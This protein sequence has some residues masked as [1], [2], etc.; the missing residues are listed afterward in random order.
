VVQIR[1]CK[2]PHYAV[3]PVTSSLL[4]PNV[5]RAL[6]SNTLNVRTILLMRHITGHKSHHIYIRTIGRSTSEHVTPEV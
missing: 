1:N 5:K 2:A 6:F 3:S 4:D